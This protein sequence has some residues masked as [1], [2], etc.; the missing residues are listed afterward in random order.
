MNSE[1]VLHR[2]A[3]LLMLLT[4]TFS[5]GETVIG[6]LRDGTVHH[7][8]TAA[9]ATHALFAQGEHGHEDGSSHGSDHEHGTPADHCTHHHGTVL[10]PRSPGVV[11][12]SHASTQVFLEPRAWLD[13]AD[14]PTL[15]PPQ[16]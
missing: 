8:S 16:A 10:H 1:I 5:Y 13:H 4:V 3:A 15:R 9:A 12:F 7:E 14:K 2:L 11:T 6:V